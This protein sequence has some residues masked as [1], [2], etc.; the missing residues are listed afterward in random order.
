M[1]I[2]NYINVDLL[3]L[4]RWKEAGWKNAAFM[5][6]D[7][8]VKLRVSESFTGNQWKVDL[9]IADVTVHGD[10]VDPSLK[11]RIADAVKR[12]CDKDIAIIRMFGDS[13]RRGDVKR[14]IAGGN[15]FKETGYKV[16]FSHLYRFV[17]A[18]DGTS[19]DQID[20]IYLVPSYLPAPVKVGY[21]EDP[22]YKMGCYERMEN[23]APGTESAPADA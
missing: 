6:P 9:S 5:K 19:I 2:G 23:D 21:D 1:D 11:D 7:L 10:L 4:F 13:L 12:R 3:S 16:S 15:M 8:T 18:L 17:M 14:G 22:F 20:G